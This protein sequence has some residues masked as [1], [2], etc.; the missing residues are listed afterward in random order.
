MSI[1]DYLDILSIGTVGGLGAAL[2]VLAVS[3]L[4][5]GIIYRFHNV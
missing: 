2:L 1:N 5:V 3:H 4:I